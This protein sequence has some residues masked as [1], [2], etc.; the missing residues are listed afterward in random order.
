[1]CVNCNRRIAVVF[2]T[3]MEKDRT[4][5]E[6]YCLNCARKL[7]IRPVNDMLSRLGVSEEDL[8]RM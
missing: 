1:M 6:G 5:N 3:R 8:D 7:G 4:V 2:I